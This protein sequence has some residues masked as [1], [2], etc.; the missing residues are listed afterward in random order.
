MWHFY[1]SFL[2][3]TDNETTPYGIWGTT[4]IPLYNLQYSIPGYHYVLNATTTISPTAVNEITVDQGHDSQYNGT[5][6]GSGDWTRAQTGVDLNTLYAPY[7]DLITGFNFA[8]TRI[9]NSP[10]FSTSGNPFY[11]A[12]TN[13]EVSDNFSK[14]VRSHLFK[15]GFYFDHN[16]KVQPSGATYA[17]SY[18]FGDN[19]SNPLDT[20]FGF[21]NAALGVFNS[22]Q[23]A[24]T[25]ANA[26]PIYNQVEWYAQDT[27]KV[28][29][30]LAINYGARFYWLQPIHNSKSNIANFFPQTWQGSQAPSLLSPAFNSSS[31][32]VALDPTTGQTYP[33]V[34]IGSY[35]STSGNPLNGLSNLGTSYITKS[36]GILVA[37]RIGL[38]FDLTGQQRAVLHAGGGIFYDRTR[39]DPYASLLGNPPATVQPT[40]NYG[41]I[42]D[43]G[44]S[45]NVF[46]PPGLSTFSTSSAI[47][48]TYNYNVGLQGKLPFA[49]LVDVAYV[50]SVTNH[51]LQY[52]NLNAV[53]FGADFLP[54]NQDPTLR[55]TSPNALAGS[56]ALSPQ[57]LR[58]YIGYGDINEYLFSGNSN[59][60][61]LQISL[62]R[63]FASGL[64]FGLA[65]TWSKC[66]D[67]TDDRSQIRFDQY[68]H[69]ALYGPCDNNVP[70][71]LVINYVYTLPS[72]SDRL[73]SFNNRVTRAVLN[74]WQISGVSTFQRGTPYSV[75]LS[76]NGVSGANFTGTPSW[77]PVPLCVSNPTAGTTDNPF[78]RLNASAFALPAVGS[79]GLGCSRNF[80]YGPGVNN[81][82]MS[83]QKNVPIGEHTRLELRGEAFNIFNHTQFIGVNN[84]IDFSGLNNPVVTNLPYSSTGALANIGGFGAVSG[85]RSP[86]ILQLVAKFVF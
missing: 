68:T 67:T 80:V 72:L 40:V 77:N 73:G 51:Q 47:P 27:W 31:Q 11:N 49:L 33:S 64:F 35:L 22:F 2:K 24:S 63:R 70:Q 20:G 53:P 55:A 3:A 28:N 41:N 74:N 59:Y 62:N 85:S 30:R 14:T 25:Y 39:T 44:S 46:S 65:Y 15:F 34:D 76:V 29:S 6:P 16:W 71:N 5:Q 56:N 57:F 75:N 84:T 8:G 48:T 42:A 32:R 81:W 10:Y 66:M 38:S 17:G 61:S 36:P 45:S 21:A 86:R 60:N 13:T 19:P 58:P 1:A 37:P 23:Q 69:T 78:D 43:L 9:G 26:Y 18:D 50:G 79:I 7:Q 52:V 83:L 4:N 82:D 12:N 54:Q